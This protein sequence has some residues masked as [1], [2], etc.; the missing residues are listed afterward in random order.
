MAKRHPATPPAGGAPHPKEADSERIVAY[1]LAG[2]NL[3]C[4]G[5]APS[6]RGDIWEPVTSDE[7]PDGGVCAMC[8]VDVLIPPHPKEA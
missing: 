5:C 8:H 2:Q 6:P 7:L 4:I 1:R 3:R